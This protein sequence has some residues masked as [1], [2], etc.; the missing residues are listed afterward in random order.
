[1]PDANLDILRRGSTGKLQ[2]RINLRQSYRPSKVFLPKAVN[3]VQP[4]PALNF[5]MPGLLVAASI[6]SSAYA[7]FP[8]LS[9]VIH[10]AQQ[11]IK[12]AQNP[13]R[14]SNMCNVTQNPKGFYENFF[15]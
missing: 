9:L 10:A 14:L 12:M 11:P 2:N 1:M 15:F 5:C 4:D 6:L 13:K 3:L 7:S 8:F